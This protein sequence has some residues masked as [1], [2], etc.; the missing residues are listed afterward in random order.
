MI[1]YFSM[2]MPF[3][4]EIE[5]NDSIIKKAVFLDFNMGEVYTI[6]I[7]GN[8]VNASL[9]IKNYIL[10]SVLNKQIEL[11][12]Q[13]PQDDLSTAMN[14]EKSLSEQNANHIFRRNNHARS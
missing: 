6:N 12:P 7:D 8:L 5:E 4:L 3:I 13:I 2:L 14:A 1:K 9:D 11:K 10:E